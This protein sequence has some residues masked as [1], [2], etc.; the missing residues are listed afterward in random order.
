MSGICGIVRFGGDPRGLDEIT[1]MTAAMAFRGPDGMGHWQDETAALGHCLLRTTEE[2]ADERQPLASDDG[3][4]VLVIDGTLWNAGELRTDLIRAGA[5]LRSRADSELVL[6][7]YETW[8]RDFLARIDGDFALAIWDRRRR[9][10]YC[11]RDRIGMRPFHWHYSPRC[12]FCFG[13]D[14][15]ALLALSSV[16]RRLNEARL[17]D[18]ILKS[19]EGYDLTSTF[20][21][22]ISRLPPAHSL[23]VSPG[24]LHIERY[25]SFA[26]RPLI[27]LK[28]DAAYEDAFRT[29]VRG[30]VQRRLR[31]VGTTASMLSGGVDSATVTALARNLRQ[32]AGTGPHPTFSAVGPDPAQCSETRAIYASAGMAGLK[33]HFVNYAELGDLTRELVELTLTPPTPFD[34]HM[35]LIRS[36]YLAAH[37]AGIRAVLDGVGSDNVLNDGGLVPHLIRRGRLV[38]AW[39]EARTFMGRPRPDGGFKFL[40]A[41]KMAVAPD[42]LRKLRLAAGSVRVD[43]DDKMAASL[44]RPEFARQVDLGGRFRQHYLKNIRPFKPGTAGYRAASF[45][46]WVIPVARERYEREAARL[47]IEPRDPFLDTNV[48]DFCVSLPPDQVRRDGWPKSILRRSMCGAIPSSV[49]WRPERTQLG[50]QVTE[51]VMR[52]AGPLEG[53]IGPHEMEVLSDYLD[54]DRVGKLIRQ[55]DLGVGLQQRHLHRLFEAVF[56]SRMLL[57]ARGGRSANIGDNRS[58][59]L[60]AGD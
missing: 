18:A 44:I 20:W 58:M 6:R 38:K 3:S 16:P 17:A 37:R 46:T 36:I 57:H 49:L 4:V 21:Q 29:V 47:Q 28:S 12:G 30:A 9:E 7:S 24:G 43:R 51:A 53:L 31:G 27:K 23:L 50:P 8:G 11:A 55:P 59:A 40:Q 26:A 25:W 39:R 2:A 42:I 60:V 13:S 19:L 15:E 48:V 33:P 32:E 54:I 34:G 14:P 5:R 52:A 56:V 10:L 45:L 35:T 22:D 1:R 41:L